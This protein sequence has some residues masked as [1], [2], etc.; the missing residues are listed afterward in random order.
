MFADYVSKINKSSKP[1]KRGV[2]VSEA[3]IYKHDPKNFKLR[4]VAVPIAEMV[5]VCVSPYK[6]SFVVIHFKDPERDLVFNLGISGPEKHSEFVA[7][8]Y[9]VYNELTGNIL[10]INFTDNIKYVNVPKKKGVVAST[11]TFQSSKETQESTLKK[12]K[13][14]NNIV[15]Y[16]E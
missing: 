14:N 7:V 10:P 5:D 6:D 9:Q 2:I 4:K 12:G 16:P 3:N 15:L 1:Q 13:N 11:I 8:L